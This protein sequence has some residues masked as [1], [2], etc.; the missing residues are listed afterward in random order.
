M[1]ALIEKL[2]LPESKP[3]T[4]L[5]FSLL[6]AVVGQ[7]LSVKAAATIFSRFV[8][9]FPNNYPAA[10][11]LLDLPEE[12]LRGAGLSGQKLK[13]LKAIATYKLQGHLE[14]ELIAYLADEELI[15]HLTRINGVGRWTAEML[16]IFA[17]DRP[18]VFPIDD[19]GIKNAMIKQYGLTE[20]KQLL[21][22]KLLEIAKNW[23]PYRTLACK[24][25]WKS[26]DNV[27]A[28]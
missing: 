5:Y 23:Q 16:L 6:R 18:D 17:L 7:Q 19:L 8:A 14:P 2:A 10:S 24:Y 21:K 20:E 3:E 22:N 4:D 9:L 12:T 1:I 25:L 11:L 15:T 13:Y 26:L 28:Q 27:P